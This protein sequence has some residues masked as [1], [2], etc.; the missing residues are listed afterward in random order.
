MLYW[1]KSP[2]SY[3]NFEDSYFMTHIAIYNLQFSRLLYFFFSFWKD[4]QT[5]N[6]NIEN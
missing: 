5:W 1:N 4:L 6:I 2:S 3:A